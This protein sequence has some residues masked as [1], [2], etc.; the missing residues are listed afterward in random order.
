MVEV[1][2]V[3]KGGRDGIRRPIGIYLCYLAMAGSDIHRISIRSAQYRPGPDS[4]SRQHFCI[5]HYSTLVMLEEQPSTIP[6]SPGERVSAYAE[7]A[8]C[9]NC[10]LAVEKPA[11]PRPASQR[12][13]PL[14][15]IQ[16]V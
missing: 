5:T 9:A 8:A 4:K 15:D 3:A 12:P 11:R 1:V 7:T 6:A 14:S 16:H 10:V 2:I 13:I